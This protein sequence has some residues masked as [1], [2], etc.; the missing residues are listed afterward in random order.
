M[1]GTEY[2]RVLVSGAPAYM[3]YWGDLV[4]ETHAPGGHIGIV[5]DD[6]GEFAVHAMKHIYKITEEGE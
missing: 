3:E 1:D 4:L 6:D 2:P 5:K